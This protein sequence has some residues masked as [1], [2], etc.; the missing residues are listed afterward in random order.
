MGCGGSKGESE[1]KDDDGRGHLPKKLELS[2][3][4]WED[5]LSCERDI[6]IYQ[7]RHVVEMLKVRT[8][9]KKQLE[10]NVK[11]IE[12][13]LKRITRE[14]DKSKHG[15]HHSNAG[16]P[17]QERLVKTFLMKQ[18]KYDELA[19]Y[20]K[21]EHLAALNR[22]EI[23][24]KELA[25]TKQHVVELT[26][27]CELLQEDVDDLKELMETQDKLL[28]SW[29][30]GEYGSHLENQLEEE[31]EMLELKM[32]K[33]EEVN[34]KWRQAQVMI[35]YACKQIGTSVEKWEGIM[36]LSMTA[37]EA[38][39]R[40]A[41]ETRNNLIAAGQNLQGAHRYL[42]H[43]EFPYC[44]PEEVKMLNKATSYVF[45][46]MQ[47][48]ARQCHALD[49]YSAAHRRCGALLQWCNMVINVPIRKNLMAVKEKTKKARKELRCER[50]KLIT[51]QVQQKLGK[52]VQ[53][54]TAD[55]D[56]DDD[57]T[58]GHDIIAN[59]DKHRDTSSKSVTM[60]GSYTEL[61]YSSVSNAPSPLPMDELAQPP[62]KHQLFGTI[63]DNHREHHTNN[64]SNGH[65]NHNGAKRG[66]RRT[67]RVTNDYH[68]HMNHVN[69][70]HHSSNAK[71]NNNHHLPMSHVPNQVE[72][73]GLHFVDGHKVHKKIRDNIER[74]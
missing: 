50:A 2:E 6:S 74:F 42:P 71:S 20:E 13:E 37:M 32:Q 17:S 38:R 52:T 53:I 21:A 33:Y 63:D 61:D 64:K 48:K 25:G 36:K 54:S 47:A 59:E 43:I 72:E 19:A 70:S 3:S 55:M 35:E 34:F 60:R 15:S 46:D 9:Q 16:S 11:R 10:E 45:T 18:D 58:M 1:S 65:V 29:F 23:L 51:S 49:C 30:D 56:F 44:T 66:Q 31:V 62:D 67:R 5:Y 41:E 69:G 40:L 57:L 24:K 68:E 14:I 28:D 7:K 4:S 27:E 39:Y 73:D 22:R 26:H 12:D 8:E